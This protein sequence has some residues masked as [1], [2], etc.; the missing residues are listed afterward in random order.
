MSLPTSAT[1]D[2]ADFS[3][4]DLS[5]LLTLGPSDLTILPTIS[6]YFSYNEGLTV[7]RCRSEDTVEASLR[8]STP[9]PSRF[10]LDLVVRFPQLPDNLGDLSA[11]RVGLTVADDGGRGF[12]LFFAK[13]GMAVS[14]VDSL[15]GASALPDT[16]D[17]TEEVSDQFH[18]IRIAVDGG[19]RRAYVFV[20]LGA[21]EQPAL[22]FIVPVEATPPSVTDLFRVFVM[23]TV[24]EPGDMEI[25]SLR[26]AS[27]L[28]I[29]NYPPVANAGPDRVV[30]VGQAARLDGRSSY[31]IEGAA[32]TYRWRMIDAPFGSTYAS[33]C[34][35][36]TTID[37]GDFDGATDKVTVPPAALPAWLAP[38]DLIVLRALRYE[39]LSI[40]TLTGE[41]TVTIDSIPDDFTDPEPGRFLGQSLILDRTSET[42]TVLGDIAGLYRFDL[43]VNDGEGD[44][45]PAEVLLNITAAR[46]PFGIEPDVSP[47]WKA[48]GDEWRLIEGVRLFE[49]AWR[50]VAQ[51]LAGK[52]LEAW[53]YHYNSSIR[54]AQTVFQRKWV[55]YRT[56]EAETAPDSVTV[57]PRYG[58]KV[59]THEYENSDPA[60]TG[61]DLTI[62]YATGDS[63]D[64]LTAVEVV[65]TA[66]DLDTTLS[67]LVAALSTAPGFEGTALKV[68]PF[69]DSLDYRHTDVCGSIDDGDSNGFTDTLS[70]TPAS[71]P[72]WLAQ[73]DIVVLRGIRSRVASFNN[74]TGEL[75]ADDAVFPD[76]LSNEPY[77]LYRCCRLAI[78]AQQY[79]KLSGTALGLLGLDSG[80][81]SLTGSAGIRITDNVY[82]AG[83][84]VDLGKQG[85]TR[86]DLLVLN[87]G[88]SFRIDRLVSD[89]LDP[90][91][92]Q[93][94]LV[95]DALPLDA[96]AEW[97][98]PSVVRS[99]EV[100]YEMVGVYPGDL[101]KVE[102]FDKVE[103]DT[104]LSSSLVVAQKGTQ[105]GGALDAVAA[106]ALMDPD[107]WE[108]RFVGVR[109]RKAIRLPDD[110]LSVPML[111]TKIPV[112]ASPVYY[113]EN[114][115]YILE[116]F[117]R[118]IGGAPIPML[119]FSDSVFIDTD[120]EP[121]D[122]LWAELTLFS[123]AGNVEDLFGRLVGFLRDDAAAFPADFN[124]VAGVAGLLY[125]QQRGPTLFALQVGAQILLGQPFAEVAGY[126][127]EV[128]GDYSPL[129][130][131]ILIRDDDGNVPT[132]SEVV[133]A[134]YYKK[135][136]L[137]PSSQSGLALNPATGFPWVAADHVP[138]FSP[139]GAGIDVI[140]LYTDP[141][142][143]IPF[144]RSG[145][146]TEVEKFHRF[147]VQFNADLVSVANIQLL[148]ALITKIK[149]TYTSLVLSGVRG[150]EE[151]L[152]IDD[153]VEASLVL[154]VF[155][156]PG[157]TLHAFM[158]DDY[159]GN[160]VTAS[161]FDDG[162]THFDGIVDNPKDLVDLVLEFTWGGGAISEDLP[163]GPGTIDVTGGQTGI[164]G[165]TFT[166]S[167][168]MTLAAG[169]YRMIQVAKG[170]GIVY[171]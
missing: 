148:F 143:W 155:D 165:S 98:V 134:Y 46:A 52:L 139:L 22:H 24:T 154:N 171:P 43:V 89:A 127:E 58:M 135:D 147:M 103:S 128:R 49:E 130:G 102:V 100:D 15:G 16:A 144:V 99:T 110:V 7:L 92:N 44:S 69:I 93:R 38:G 62:E 80:A 169:T 30:P 85:V 161:L 40:N 108:V 53:Q 17:I 106:A 117:Y 2:L 25:M 55:A 59:A 45:E 6:P 28:V 95:F 13:T 65:L 10:T 8:F 104:T 21:T 146:M 94:V 61:F 70:V 115:D 164:P 109:R 101:I 114:V 37:D 145:N 76:A 121:S 23:G 105:L 125:A 27:D 132:E 19:L 87:N 151:D 90:I 77:R 131:R 141:E 36:F 73:G 31:D 142:W 64:T 168:G 133:R 63:L 107:R 68:P 96:S 42:P 123:N 81:N 170:Q 11:R 112:G 54:D 60:V 39:I 66:D 67:D 159:R 50:G 149:P 152:D 72:S 126:V 153:D 32:L 83:D 82:Y 56:M 156:S 57:L 122:V 124:Y 3:G 26:L 14:R 118:E 111:Q 84:Y 33:D 140:D 71:L 167:N 18:T 74:S 157:P 41:I 113:R 116:P 138:Q 166:S 163:Y 9:I 48:V 78:E 160:G 4:L 20:G 97:E 137:D 162:Y 86:Y 120:T 79:F 47:L 12:T 91:P 34:S 29:A 129:T 51:I 150:T 5:T 35:N 158:Y 1:W 75:V 119:Q 88:E 136:P